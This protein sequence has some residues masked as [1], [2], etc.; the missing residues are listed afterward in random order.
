MQD[1][2]MEN[3]SAQPNIPEMADLDAIISKISDMMKTGRVDLEEVKMDLEDFKTKISGEEQDEADMMDKE[4][5]MAGMIAYS[6]VTGK[7]LK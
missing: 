7:S 4:H 1:Q 3:D 5:G 6:I 2:M